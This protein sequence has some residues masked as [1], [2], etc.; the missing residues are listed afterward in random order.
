[1]SHNNEMA[2]R[3]HQDLEKEEK[4]HKTKGKKKATQK[5][6]RRAP[7][8]TQVCRCEVVST[9]AAAG[10]GGGGGYM[11]IWLECSEETAASK[12]SGTCN[13]HNNIL[14]V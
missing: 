4:R 11:P 1:M 10:A 13:A 6:N 14:C 2:G 9:K 8:K 7:F 5:S 3:N 12:C